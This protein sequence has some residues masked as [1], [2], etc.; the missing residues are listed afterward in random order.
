MSI[1]NRLIEMI[2]SLDDESADAIRKK[3]YAIICIIFVVVAVFLWIAMSGAKT[4]AKLDQTVDRPKKIVVGDLIDEKETWISRLEEKS[5]SMEAQVSA[6]QK[7]NSLLSKRIENLE[8]ALVSQVKNKKPEEDKKTDTTISD[9]SF[10]TG[11]IIAPT[12]QTP[13]KGIQN[14]FPLDRKNRDESES[15]SP[16]PKIFQ[17]SLGEM[18]ELHHAKYYAVAGTSAKVVLTSGVVVS[19]SVST[20][21]NPQPIIM[22]IADQGNMP[23]GW[24][25]RLKDAV[26][27]GS[28]Y[29]D[30]SAERAQC[31]IHTLSFVEKSGQTVEVFVEG[32]IIGEDGAPGLRGLVVDK[33]GKVVREA[34]MAGMLSGMGD[35]FKSSTQSSVFPVS[36]FGQTNALKTDDVLKSGAAQG[37]SNAL[38]KLAEYSIKRAES[39]SP[40]LVVHPGRVVD[41][42]FKKGFDLRAS[43]QQGA[44]KLQTTSSTPQKFGDAINDN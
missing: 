20:Q 37:A 12:F 31:R 2:K 16:L 4:V 32:W 40:V 22:H 35:F 15:Y 10:N 17:S 39:M 9:Q 23:R 26:M 28:C 30:L 1:R 19:T 36:P 41:V 33:A 43:R 42:V 29:G 8:S 21:S 44:P 7:E 6:Y 27:I 25:S 14:P 13:Q 38:D 5:D 24:K 11:G 3:H 18:D 34:F